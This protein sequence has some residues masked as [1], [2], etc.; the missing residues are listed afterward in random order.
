MAFVIDDAFL[1]A[2]LTAPPMTDEEFAEFRAEHG[3]R[4]GSIIAELQAWAKRDDS[5]TGE[6]PV[7]DFVLDL[8]GVWDP[9]GA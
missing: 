4:N 6:G 3:A 5:I 2:T 9:L 7:A 8:A 1:P